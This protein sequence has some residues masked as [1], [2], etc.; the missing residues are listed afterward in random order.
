M[1]IFWKVIFQAT[2]CIQI[3]T[4]GCEKKQTDQWTEW[5]RSRATYKGEGYIGQRW[6]ISR[7]QENMLYLM[8]GYLQMKIK[9]DPYFI[10]I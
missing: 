3:K 6:D 1:A 2:T 9:L 5:S 10:T 4:C 8:I 7:H